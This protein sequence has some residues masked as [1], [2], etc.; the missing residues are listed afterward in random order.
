M[1]TVRLFVLVPLALV[2]MSLLAACGQATP[3]VKEVVVTKEVPKEV[4]KEVEKRVVVT[5]TPVPPKAA[6]AFIFGA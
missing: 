5:S 1:K 2:V 3:E 6:E 4:V